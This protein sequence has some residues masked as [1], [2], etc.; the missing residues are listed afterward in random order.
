MISD[1]IMA[2]LTTPTPASL[3]APHGLGVQEHYIDGRFRPSVSGATF[4][5]L[6]PAT[7]EVL[8]I[9]AD[10]GEDDV[11]AAVAAARRAFEGG[12]WPRMKAVERAAVLRRVADGIREHADA[13]V[14][15]EVADIGM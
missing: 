10:G 11:A 14:A 13:L 1:T 6:N 4:E 2:E 9:A 8:A 3:A 12:S 15:R 5:T 7:N